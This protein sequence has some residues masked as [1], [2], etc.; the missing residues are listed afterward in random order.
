MVFVDL[1]GVNNKQK[2]HEDAPSPSLQQPGGT[3]AGNIE[4]EALRLKS[5]N[6][7]EGILGLVEQHP[8]LQQV[9][10]QSLA[11]L[12]QEADVLDDKDPTPQEVFLNIWSG[13][14]F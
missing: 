10:E 3:T 6:T 8:A 4:Q 1:S 2:H 13:Q 5:L 12:E 11:S 9:L 14:G 7:L